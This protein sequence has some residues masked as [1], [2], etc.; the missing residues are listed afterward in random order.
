MR[1]TVSFIGTISNT[2]IGEEMLVNTIINLEQLGVK[3]NDI[4]I[5]V[6]DDL[7][8]QNRKSTEPIVL[9]RLNSLEDEFV[10]L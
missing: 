6:L 1:Y 3:K 7:P 5:S 4:Q 8:P 2:V 10:P 9:E